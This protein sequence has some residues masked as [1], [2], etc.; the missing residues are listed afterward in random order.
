MHNSAT[1]KRPKVLHIIQQLELLGGAERQLVYLIQ[2]LSERYAFHVVFYHE[3]A[4]S[5]VEA[6]RALGVP[7]DFIARTPGVRGQWRFMRD[8]SQRVREIAPDILQ[9]WLISAHVWG[10]LAY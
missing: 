9:L 3:D 10:S 6:L 5:H 2:A 7:V 4:C 1:P 8:L